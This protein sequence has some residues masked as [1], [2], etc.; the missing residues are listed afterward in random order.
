MF[1]SD[2]FFRS[3]IVFVFNFGLLCEQNNS[4]ES[5]LSGTNDAVKDD[6]SEGLK[7]LEVMRGLFGPP[8]PA[9]FGRSF[10]NDM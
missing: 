5:F 2:C 6:S 8:G 3:D 10:A 4:L 1:S 7:F 9:D